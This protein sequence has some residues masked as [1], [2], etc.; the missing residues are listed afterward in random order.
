MPQLKF[1]EKKNMSYIVISVVN[2][3]VLSCD[4]SIL[5]DTIL[6]T[7]NLKVTFLKATIQ[8]TTF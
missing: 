6:T 1:R 7:T 2:Y 8:K 3:A 4:Q 5:T